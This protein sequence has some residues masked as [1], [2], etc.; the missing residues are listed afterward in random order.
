MGVQLVL[1]TRKMFSVI[2][3]DCL[4]LHLYTNAFILFIQWNLSYRAT[5]KSNNSEFDKK[6]K[7]LSKKMLQWSNKC[8]DFEHTN[9]ADENGTC[10]NDC[11]SKPNTAERLA[12]S[13]FRVSYL[14]KCAQNEA[15]CSFLWKN[16]IQIQYKQIEEWT[17]S[18]ITLCRSLG[19]FYNQGK[20]N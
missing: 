8:S 11:R 5:L 4:P 2:Q 18:M 10:T 19:K 17:F 20:H 3:C 7:I 12:E 15:K 6:K 14:G 9:R 1:R 13:M 16:I